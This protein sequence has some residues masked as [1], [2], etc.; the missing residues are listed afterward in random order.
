MLLCRL[1]IWLQ[2]RNKGVPAKLPIIIA[3]A[4]DG[5][6]ITLDCKLKHAMISK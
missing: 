3:V 2:I 5:L 1:A 6:P 4:M